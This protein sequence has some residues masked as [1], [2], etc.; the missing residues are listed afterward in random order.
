MSNMVAVITGGSSGIG[1]ATAEYFAEQEYEVYELSRSGKGGKDVIHITADVTDEQ[2]LVNAFNEICSRSG[3]IDVLVNNAGFGISGAVEHTPIETA[4]KQFDVNFFGT[5]L[6]TKIALPYLK[7][8]GGIIINVSSVAAALAIPFQA[9]Y[10]A[11][12]A[13]INAFSSALALEVKPFGVRVTALM[14]GDIATGFTA[15]REKIDGE[16]YGE[17]IER[18]VSQ[19]E[20]DEKN[21]MKPKFIAEQIFRLSQI[22]NPRPLY[23]AGFKYK[24]FVWLSKI[25]PSKLVAKI[26]GAMY[27]K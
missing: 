17:R 12:K 24:F 6:V 4:K 13:A 3:R 22:K 20:K 10:S 2:S 27:A 26:L 7:I 16:G 21:G 9:Y 15:V 19:M 5:A 8:K 23:T 25:L 18:S 11:A 14:P 1:K